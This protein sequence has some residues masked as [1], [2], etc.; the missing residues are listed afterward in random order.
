MV[1]ASSYE[2]CC[3]GHGRSVYVENIFIRGLFFFVRGG[4]VSADFFVTGDG[5]W[6]ESLCGGNYPRLTTHY[7]I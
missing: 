4:R 1:R 3:A 7:L 5:S 6:T 2:T